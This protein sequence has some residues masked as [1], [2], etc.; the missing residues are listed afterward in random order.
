MTAIVTLARV[1]FLLVA[2]VLEVAA[3]LTF[4]SVE[5]LVQNNPRADAP[6]S[7]TPWK[8]FTIG[9]R[10]EP[11]R[12]APVPVGHRWVSNE[13]AGPRRTVAAP[14]MAS[15]VGPCI[16]VVGRAGRG[17]SRDGQG[18][19]GH[20]ETTHEGTSVPQRSARAPPVGVTFS[21][22]SPLT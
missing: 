16:G 11:G 3:E 8:I 1:H 15:G 19:D 9:A 7:R 2:A 6:A 17:A 5:G 12:A 18:D 20:G 13:G 10:D 14:F 22:E 21:A 4:A